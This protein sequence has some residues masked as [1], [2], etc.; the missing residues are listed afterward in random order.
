MGYDAIMSYYVFKDIIIETGNN[1]LLGILIINIV[2]LKQ[3]HKMIE[4][5]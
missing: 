4:A 3:Q 1:S 2:T 5:K